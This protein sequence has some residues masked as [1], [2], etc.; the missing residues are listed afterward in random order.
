[1][2]FVKDK[3]SNTHRKFESVEEAR[4]HIEN[5]TGYTVCFK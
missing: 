5:N 4:E 2:V 3:D 1:M